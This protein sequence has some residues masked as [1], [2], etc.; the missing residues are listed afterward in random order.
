[1]YGCNLYLL[2]I[3]ERMLGK[4]GTSMYDPERTSSCS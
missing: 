4:P 3:I 2:L 1:M